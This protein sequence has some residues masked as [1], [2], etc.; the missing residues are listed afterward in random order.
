MSLVLIAVV[1][2]VFGQYEAKWESLDRRPIPN[3]FDEAKFGIFI[4]W[5]V[6]SVPSWAPKGRYAEWYWHDMQDK[7]S[8][9]WQFHVTNYGA[10]FPYQEFA[11]MFRAELFDP[12]RWADLFQKSGARYVVLTS[13]HH[14][15]FCLWGSKESWNWNSVDVGPRRDLIAE[16]AQAVRAKGLRFGLYYSLYEWFNPLYRTDVKRYVQ[17]HMLPQL[18]ELVERYR[19]SLIFADGEWD[20]PSDVWRS[21]E[22]LSWLFN[23]SPVKDEVVVN[24]RWG[25]ETR[26]VHGGYFTSE[27]GHVGG[28]KVLAPGR[29]WEENRGMGSSFG[30]NRN[31]DIED[32]ATA[33]DLIALLVDVVSR[34]GNLLLNVGPTAD[35][36]IPVIMQERLLQI[37]EWLRINGDSIY[38]SQPVDAAPPEGCRL[39]QK[40][41]LLFVH[42]LDSPDRKFVELPL[43]LGPV[44]RAYLM[45]D[46]AKTPLAISQEQQKIIISLPPVPRDPYVTVIAIER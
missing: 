14:D 9:T 3:W 39:T 38:G 33:K 40:G 19:P 43:S 4:H 2:P 21:E 41:N 30:Y 10:N 45:M 31:E 29:K 46:P 27:Y 35:G 13:K 18:K 20:H 8:P 6:Y 28:G 44:S 26:S 36:R 16:L 24:D 23:E 17:E 22:F 11:P 7:N 15:G 12:N 37:G 34:G 25:K 5:G 1:S 32:Y 42:I